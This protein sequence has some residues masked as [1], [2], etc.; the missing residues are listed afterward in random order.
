MTTIGIGTEKGG[1][2]LKDGTDGWT[3]DGPLFP[4]WKVTTWSTTPGGHYLAAIGSN[5]FGPALHRSP[6]LEAWEQIPEGPE[7]PEDGP[8]LNQVWTVVPHGNA[9]LAGVD[10]AGL[11][12]SHDDGLTWQPVT[13][14]NDFPGRDEWFPGLGG[15]CAHHVLTAG[16]RIWVAI[17]AVGVFR[18]DD[19]GQTFQRRDEG[20]RPTVEDPQ[21]G[22]C[23]HGI[24]SDPSNPDHIWRQDHSGVYRSSDGADSWERI[25]SGLPATFGFPVRRDDRSGRIF[26]VPLESDANRFPVDGALRVFRSDDAGDSW[27]VAGSGWDAASTYTAVLR[28]AM[29]VDGDGGVFFGTAGGDVWATRDAGD[30]WDRIPH[31]FPRILSVKV[32]D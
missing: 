11:F 24:T 8:T 18:S 5:W 12:R 21:D 13:A 32:L 23:V 10:E 9:L 4:G 20:V 27:K 28:G 16:E 17:S 31:S 22:F 29:D 15:L 19:D 14:L 30:S 1:F 25:E 2:V 7:Y 26:V 6:D 3:L